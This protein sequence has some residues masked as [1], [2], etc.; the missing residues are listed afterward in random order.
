MINTN[1]ILAKGI[2]PDGIIRMGIRSRLAGVLA[3]FEK[4][5]CEQRQAKIMQHIAE[6]KASPLAIA[7]DEANQQ[8]YELPTRFLRKF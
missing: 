8:H 3:P 4:L 2:V 6:L 7:T 5:N 1:E